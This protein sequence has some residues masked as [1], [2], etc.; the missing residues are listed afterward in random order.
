MRTRFVVVTGTDMSFCE[1]GNETLGSIKCGVFL[2]YLSACWS[3][4]HML[5]VVSLLDLSSSK[6]PSKSNLMM[7]MMMINCMINT[8]IHDDG[9]CDNG[10]SYGNCEVKDG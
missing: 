4:W 9:E 6:L 7:M 10:N 8:V 1:H 5:R 3:F 2:Y